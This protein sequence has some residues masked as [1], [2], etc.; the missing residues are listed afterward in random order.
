MDFDKLP[1]GIDASVQIGNWHEI[2]EGG[3]S[4]TELPNNSTYT[5]APD[6]V[7][8]WQKAK[9]D[10]GELVVT[11]QKNLVAGVAGVLTSIA[12]KEAFKP[13]DTFL[14]SEHLSSGYALLHHLAVLHRHGSVLLMSSASP[15]A[16]LNLLLGHIDKSISESPTPTITESK[17]RPTILLT[18][19]EGMA[20]F[21]TQLFKSQM[22]GSWINSFISMWRERSLRQGHLIRGA[23]TSTLPV[24]LRLIYVTHST[25]NTASFV[26]TSTMFTLIRSF[27]GAQVIYVLT[28]KF[29]AGPVAQS[30]AYDYREAITKDAHFGSPATTVAL[31][32]RETDSEKLKPN[33]EGEVEK[34]V[35][36]ARG[37]SVLAA[38]EETDVSLGIKGKFRD[39]LTLEVES[40]L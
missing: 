28:S 40:P 8:V 20:A 12:P 33:Y 31:K 29:V 10:V 3:S 27:L 24:G 23:Y 38:S 5:T 17:I 13:S 26:L 37:P 15:S 34:G 1:E 6:V 4:S 30:G 36:Y 25:P 22:H 39:D 14:S 21:N 9:G 32:L 2:T 7:T 18:S 35:V 19:C 11:P 16:N